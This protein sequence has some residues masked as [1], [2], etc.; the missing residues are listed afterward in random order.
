MLYL[1]LGGHL[2]V[3]PEVG[4]GGLEDGGL[5]HLPVAGTHHGAQLSHQVVKLNTLISFS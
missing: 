2:L 1:V 4:D 3:L 5:V